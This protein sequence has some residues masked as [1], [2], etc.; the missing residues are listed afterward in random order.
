[1]LGH[2]PGFGLGMGVH[3]VDMLGGNSGEV[4]RL[5]CMLDVVL[6]YFLMEL[7]WQKRQALF[8]AGLCKVDSLL[9]GSA[10]FFV[11]AAMLE[12]MMSC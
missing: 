11:R 3:V 4:G 2:L 9:L 5:V 1:M 12:Y 7:G 8:T 10:I 6:V